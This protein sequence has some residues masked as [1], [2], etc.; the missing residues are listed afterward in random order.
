[1]MHACSMTPIFLATYSVLKTVL[2][3]RRVCSVLSVKLKIN[4]YIDFFM[5]IYKAY[6]PIFLGYNAYIPIF[7]GYKAYIP[8]FLGYKAYIPIHSYEI[9]YIPILQHKC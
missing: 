3:Y 1:M 9:A 8:I 2:F 7:L 4:R 5:G 6:I